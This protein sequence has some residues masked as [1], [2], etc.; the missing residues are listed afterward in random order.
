MSDL[1]LTYHIYQENNDCRDKAEIFWLTAQ[2]LKNVL[3]R[4]RRCRFSA[5]LLGERHCSGA[6]A[7]WSVSGSHLHCY[8][9]DR[10]H[11][12]FNKPATLVLW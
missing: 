3:M 4:W 6:R 5:W 9:M 2:I 11:V 12:L 10:A 7:K 1:H 8:I